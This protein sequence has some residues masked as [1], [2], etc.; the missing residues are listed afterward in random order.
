MA[1]EVFMDIPK[2]KDLSKK[3]GDIGQE[4]EQIS[5]GMEALIAVLKTSALFGNAGG[6]A[7][8]QYLEKVKPTVDGFGKKCA[9]LSTDL[10]SAVRSYE[11]GDALG[12]T[13]F[14]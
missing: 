1:Q 12:A 3:F 10:E 2:V 7:Q 5:K 6:I 11:N 8:A 4:L 9:E 14:H 13:K